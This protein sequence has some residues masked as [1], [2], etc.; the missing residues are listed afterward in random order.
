MICRA[1]FV[2]AV[3]ASPGAA[4]LVEVGAGV[5]IP[6]GDL[7]ANR[8]VGFGGHASIWFEIGERMQAGSTLEYA[9][10]PFDRFNDENIV[11]SQGFALTVFSLLAQGRVMVAGPRSFLRPFFLIGA[12]VSRQSAAS[13][14]V[15]LND[16]LTFAI[17]PEPEWGATVAGGAGVYAAITDE[18]GIQTEARYVLTALE[19]T[20]PKRWQFDAAIR[21]RV[22]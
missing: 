21:V 14:R 13:G 5:T 15:L 11:A 12:G 8:D 4:Q 22:N 20:K 7:D 18:V 3:A 17:S 9:R 1:M 10:L 19:E 16:G 6:T 2:V